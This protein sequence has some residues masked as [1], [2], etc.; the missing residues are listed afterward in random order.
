MN[1]PVGLVVQA[2]WMTY[3]AVLAVW[4]T[5]L[6]LLSY[7]DWAEQNF[8]RSLLC[9]CSGVESFQFRPPCVE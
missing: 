2:A 5:Q 4:T 3:L 1:C 9:A 8:L 7:V 6:L